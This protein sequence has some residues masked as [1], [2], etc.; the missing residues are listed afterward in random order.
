MAMASK[1]TNICFTFLILYL[2]SGGTSVKLVHA[3]KTWCIAKPG[4][5]DTSLQDN[6]EYACSQ[7]NC[8]PIRKG[9]PCF[10][11]NTLISHAS[12]AMNI[13]YQANGRNDWNCDF[14]GTGLIVTT[15]PSY[16]K[17]KYIIST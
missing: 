7:V 8:W 13:Y 14:S 6:I 12:V 2:L 17:C 4:T 15:D 10:Y 1:L 5:A 9:G 11:P 16:G 3:E